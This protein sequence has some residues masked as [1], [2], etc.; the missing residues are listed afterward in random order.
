EKSGNLIEAR[1]LYANSEAFWESKDAE[2]AIKKIDDETHKQVKDALKQAHQLY[3][4]GKFQAASE[5]LTKAQQLGYM[6]AVISYD[7]ALCYRQLGDSAMALG[8]LDE[9]ILASVD[10][11]RSAKLKQVRT[12]WTTGE[13]ATTRK[14]LERDH[15]LFANQLMENIG[16]DASLSSGT[17]TLET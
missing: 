10:P 11:K 2:K 7:L 4:S 14:D 17:P 15:I 5:T 12:I 3:D 6:G 8:F 13:Q 16:F 9:A 1:K